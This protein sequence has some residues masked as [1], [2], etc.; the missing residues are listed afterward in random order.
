MEDS[1][2]LA[3]SNYFYRLHWLSGKWIYGEF[4][5]AVTILIFFCPSHFYTYPAE[6]K[7]NYVFDYLRSAVIF[8]M[9]TSIFL[10]VTY[11][12]Y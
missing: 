5:Q 10:Y 2:P 11:F 9:N 3:D 1:F 12:D 8:S 4:F 6:F 7:L